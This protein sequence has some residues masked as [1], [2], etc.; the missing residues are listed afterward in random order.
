M[1]K[2]ILIANRGEVALRIIRACKELDIETVIIHSDVDKNSLPVK[3]A[4]ESL[5]IGSHRAEDSYLSIAKIISAAYLVGADGIHPGYGFL[6]ESPEFAEMVN[7]AGIKF[8]G[9][10][11]ETISILG[12]KERARALMSENNINI[13]PGSKEPFNDFKDLKAFVEET[14]FPIIIKAVSGGGGRGMR[15]VKSQEELEPFFYS[16]QKEAKVAFNDDRLYAEKYIENGRHIEIQIIADGK[17]NIIHL[18]ERDCS[19]QRK[20]QKLIE[21]TP[22][23]NLD[24]NIRKN[25][26]D[27]AIKIAEISNYEGVGTVEFIVTSEDFYFLEMNTR[28]QVEHTITEELTN[29]DIVKEQIRIA[30]GL[31]LS[32]KQKD[33]KFNGHAIQCRIN[34]EDIYNNFMPSFGK[35]EKLLIPGGFGVRFDSILYEN[36]ELPIF[37]DSMI[38]KLIVK[39]KTRLEAIKKMRVALSELKIEGIFTNRDLH[40]GIM[41]E[42]DFVRGRYDTNY[43]EK[44]ANTVFKDFLTEFGVIEDEQ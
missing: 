23:N 38:G 29:I 32:V 21:E 35:V 12:D 11:P 19:I 16:A 34:G 25:M 26:I 36:Y 30:S 20:H 24:K 27:T 1:L 5:C 9:P 31:K 39:G 41:H 2:K 4:D 42:F 18:G 8:I 10:N 17:G 13:V 28:L 40:Y 22:A 37:Y 3:L 15:I 6:S 44:K 33:V 43:L 14:G 7:K